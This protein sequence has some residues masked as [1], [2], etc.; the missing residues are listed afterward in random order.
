M[1]RNGSKSFVVFIVISKVRLKLKSNFRNLKSSRLF[2]STELT[3]VHISPWEVQKEI[4]R[5]HLQ[6]VSDVESCA[7]NE[8]KLIFIKKKLLRVD[9]DGEGRAHNYNM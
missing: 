1:F 4:F 3:D 9:D 6:Q 8:T 5:L 2:P 7:E